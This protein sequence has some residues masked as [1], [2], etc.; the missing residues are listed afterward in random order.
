META[1]KALAAPV[2][3]QGLVQKRAFYSGLLQSG[4]H[5][6]EAQVW[7]KV[8]GDIRYEEHLREWRPFHFE[9]IRVRKGLESQN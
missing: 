2:E 1:D 6:K 7:L 5:A 9:R 4:I 3:A 8:L